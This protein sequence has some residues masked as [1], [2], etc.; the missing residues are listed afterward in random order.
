M[1]PSLTSTPKASI[2]FEKNAWA[3]YVE[4]SCLRSIDKEISLND[5]LTIMSGEGHNSPERGSDET[6]EQED[7]FYQEFLDIFRYLKNRAYILDESYPFS[8]I[9]EDTIAIDLGNLTEKHLL[10]LFLL[11]SSNLFM[12]SKDEQQ[13]LT[14]SFESISQCILKQL[15]PSYHVEVFGT[16]SKPED[17]FH[18]GKLI[19]RFEK[20]AQCLHT[21]VK[22]ATKRNAHYNQASGDGGL[23]LIGF[24]QLDDPK[25]EVPFI[26]MCFSQCACSLEK[27]KEKQ[28]S[29]KFDEWNQRFEQLAHYCEFVFVPFSLRGPDGKWSNEEA[30]RMTVIPVDRIRFLHIASVKGKDCDFFKTSDAYQ[31]VQESVKDL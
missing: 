22:S 19:D 30:D 23:D 25:A 21:N 1:I 14:K 24:I 12:F 4:L 27:W 31:T 9:D 5:M 10:Y 18:G 2:K 13:R 17:I 8:F 16:A 7:A 15:Y 6:G 26:P 20:L 3:D 29:I 11:Y 28:G